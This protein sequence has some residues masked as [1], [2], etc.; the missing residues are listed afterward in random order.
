MKK[1]KINPFYI[2]IT[3]LI[4]IAMKAD[5]YAYSI[6][7]INTSSIGDEARDLF[8]IDS[9]AAQVFKSFNITNDDIYLMA[10]VVYCESRGE[11]FD[12]KVAVAS[13]ILN[14]LVSSEFPDTVSEVIF[15]PNAFSCIKGSKINVKPDEDSFDAVYKALSGMD[16]TSDST[17][18][19]N[20][21]ISTSAWTNKVSKKDTV[22]I[23]KHIFFKT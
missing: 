6:N 21:S 13:V 16:P 4:I 1:I 3:L 23:G 19:Y 12:G 2:F 8:I 14:R 10:Q 20:P 5:V 11:A 22:R 18:F 17:F 9:E 15:Q 7:T